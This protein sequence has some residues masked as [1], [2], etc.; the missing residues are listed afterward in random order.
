M[1]QANQKLSLGFNKVQ[2]NK[3]IQL[4]I[5]LASGEL[6]SCLWNVQRMYKKINDYKENIMNEKSAIDGGTQMPM[7]WQKN[8]SIYYVNTCLIY[9][10]CMLML[11]I[12]ANRH[13]ALEILTNA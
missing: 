9:V 3:Y 10:K 8:E 12:E 4:M 7:R 11:D 2:E 13:K 1:P 6:E 5:L